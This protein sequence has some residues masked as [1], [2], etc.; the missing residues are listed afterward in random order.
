MLG[1]VSTTTR[2]PP[3]DILVSLGTKPPWGMTRSTTGCRP[4]TD[5]KL[6]AIGKR[7][8]DV[9]VARRGGGETGID[10]GLAQSRGGGEDTVA[11]RRDPFGEPLEQRRFKVLNTFL[12]VED[13]RLVFLELGGDV[14]LRPRQRLP[15]DV[16]VGDFGLVRPPNF[17]V[18]A[19]DPVVADLERLDAGALALLALQ[20]RQV[21]ARAGRDPTQ[22][23]E[24]LVE[25]GAQHAAVAQRR[26]RI[27]D[28]GLG[29]GVRHVG[30]GVEARQQAVDPAA[31]AFLAA[32][33][34]EQRGEIRHRF[35]PSAHRRHV[36]WR[37]PAG[38]DPSREALQIGHGLEQVGGTLPRQ[39][40]FVEPCHGV[41]AGVE[42]FAV[43]QGLAHPPAEHP[44]AHR[45][46]R[47]VDRAEERLPLA[48]PAPRLRDL[49]IA[50][51]LGV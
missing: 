4:F 6:I 18:V 29:D 21:R 34:G 15:P 11:A 36:P 12:R 17:D 51:R 1:P 41:E 46:A 3:R 43:E 33:L 44:R 8:S 32:G 23:V 24:L 45:R 28:D 19:E 30:T 50:A 13:R 14:A 25:A 39:R 10:I 5:F 37:G 40:A 31:L 9:A 2:A 27:V 42:R 47:L 38:S 22:S 48:A 20:R 16:V 49:Q 7:G 26:R 35:E